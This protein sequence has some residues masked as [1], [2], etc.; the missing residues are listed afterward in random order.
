MGEGEGGS[1]FHL[2]PRVVNKGGGDWRQKPNPELPYVLAAY[3][4]PRHRGPVHVDSDIIS[5]P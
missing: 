1:T 3:R 4:C 5:G 2:P